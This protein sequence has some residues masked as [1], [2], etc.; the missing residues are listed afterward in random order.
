MPQSQNDKDRTRRS[1]SYQIGLNWLFPLVLLGSAV[2]V[3]LTS[4]S[5]PEIV[6]SH[7]ASSGQADGFM[8]RIIYVRFMVAMVV[9]APF[10]LAYLPSLTLNSPGA[11]IN[12]PNR[13][14]WLSPER[15]EETVNKLCRS[16]KGAALFMAV[17]LSYVHWL[18]VKANA[19]SPP[20]LSTP[21]I[22]TA[23]VMLIIFML[24][25]AWWLIK[26]FRTIP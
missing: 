4:L 15:R 2:F 7:F 6:A 25:G 26:P 9:L 5:L 19:I 21:S 18:V 22:I 24:C 8:P 17:F 10:L 14:Y 1:Q 3:W 11:R 13:E 20:L 12:L 23:I 16:M